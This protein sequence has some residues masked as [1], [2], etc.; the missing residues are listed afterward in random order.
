MHYRKQAQYRLV[1]EAL[2]QEAARPVYRQLPV[3]L[4]AVVAC[5]R[6]SVFDEIRY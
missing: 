2:E 3:Q 4:A 1:L 6:N 5:E